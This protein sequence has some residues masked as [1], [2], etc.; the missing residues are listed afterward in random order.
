MEKLK[1]QLA[2][3]RFLFKNVK[4][5]IVLVVVVRRDCSDQLSRDEAISL[6]YSSP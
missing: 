3:L 5:L 1:L 2:F 4:N 6:T